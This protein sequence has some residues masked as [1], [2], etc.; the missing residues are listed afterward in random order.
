LPASDA[1]TYAYW[2]NLQQ[3]IGTLL[4]LG[5]ATNGYS[6][7]VNMSSGYYTLELE[8]RDNGD[9][10]TYIETFPMIFFKYWNFL[11]FEVD[12]DIGYI[13]VF[14][15]GHQVLEASVENV[16]YKEVYFSGEPGNPHPW[17]ISCP[18][19]IKGNLPWTEEDMK[20]I[21]ARAQPLI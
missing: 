10:T 20:E 9:V 14:F 19:I 12:N 8:M 7:K 18:M 6:V 3:Q 16:P 17:I 21:V 15:S 5:D 4:Y 1:F 2:I 13:R 11:V